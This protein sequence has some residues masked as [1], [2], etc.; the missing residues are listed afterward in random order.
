MERYLKIIMTVLLIMITYKDRKERKISNFYIVFIFVLGILRG[1]VS[2][3]LNWIEQ[4]GGIFSVSIPMAFLNIIYPK[5]FG[6]GDIKVVGAAGVFLG[7]IMVW[8]AFSISIFFAGIYAGINL[9]FQRDKRKDVFAFGPFLS[10][11]IFLCML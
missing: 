5:C 8:K 6:A 4:L 2:D 9:L 11:G 10:L 3:E 7:E 1:F